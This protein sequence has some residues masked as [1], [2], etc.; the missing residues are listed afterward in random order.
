MFLRTLKLRRF[1]VR[2]AGTF[3]AH[4]NA[5]TDE[6]RRA[7][8]K[9]ARSWGLARKLMNIFLRD[10]LYTTYLCEEFRLLELENLFEVPLDSI[11]A[12]HLRSSAGH[13]VLPRW[14]GVKHLTPDVSEK[15][16]EYAEHLA[17]T[18]GVAK[19]HL[20]TYWWGERAV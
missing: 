10:A 9:E 3:R 4:L 8:P 20:D 17:Q 14:K 12:G 6:L 15:Y 1:S 5:A 18:C 11:T 2:R 7:L 19:V 13:G 16:Q